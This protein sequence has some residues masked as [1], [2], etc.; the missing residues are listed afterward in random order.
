M[1]ISEMLYVADRDSWRAWLEK[2]H[3]TKKEI[4][5]IY[6]KKHA[7]KP[8]VSYGDAVEEALCFGWIDSTVRT[9]DEDRYAQRFTPRKD[10]NNWSRPNRIRVRKLIREGRMTQAGLAKISAEILDERNDPKPQSRDVSIPEYFKQALMKNK[11]AWESFNNLAPSHQRN[12]IA[13]VT[14]AKKEVTRLKRMKETMEL[15][16]QN[17]RLGMK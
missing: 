17:R 3:L 10:R 7:G 14:D 4:W 13:W 16:K 6:Y 11:K 12:Y 1:N 5:L 8:T 15:L 2:H 9:I